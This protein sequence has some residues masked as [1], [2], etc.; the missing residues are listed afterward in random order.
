M[1]TFAGFA[2][3]ADPTAPGIITD[4]ENLVHT[5]RGYAGVNSL[6][7]PDSIP[8]LA[9]A[10]QGAAVVTKLDG[11]RRILAGTAAAIY[12]LSSGSWTDRSKALGYSGGAESQWSI[13]QFGDSTLMANGSNLIQRSTTGAFADVT[14]S[15][16][17]DIIFTVGAFVMALNV[18]S[19]ADGWHCCAAYDE[20]DWT[21][22]VTTQS[23]SGRLVSAPGE[24]ISGGSLGEYAIAYKQRSIFLGQYVGGSTIWDWTQVR[25]GNAGCVGKRAWCNVNGI[26]F[27]VGEDNFW[28]FDGVTPVPLA[29][30]VLRDWFASEWSATYKYKTVCAFDKT[31]NLVWIFYAS[32]NATSLDSAL[33]YHV[34]AKK[35][36]RAIVNTETALEYV[37]AG[38][39]IDGLSGISATIDGL[40]DIPFDSP[41]W[42]AGGRAL[43]V[44]NP[45]HQLQSFT[46]PSAWS[47]F[48]TGEYGDDYYYS[49]LSGVKLRFTQSP[50]AGVLQIYEKDN[51]GDTFVERESVDL[52][53][54][55][56]DV[57]RS[58]RWHK[59]KI[60]FTGNVEVT[61][62]DAKY[63]QDGEQ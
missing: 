6:A 15:P 57:L 63:M 23:A 16:V 51:S 2:P 38:I 11:S 22:S 62:M 20:T 31:T 24:I 44:F 30:G 41:Y 49:L 7:T 28:L 32:T 43:A 5:L 45:S 54:G 13:A 37:S 33:V 46:A 29:D 25:G 50:T 55:K 40:V 19:N 17:A 59:A 14:G 39:T 42:L 47:S 18:D 48:T 36:G 8:A 56:F 61:G 21:E 3:D 34:Q 10:C 27:V 1:I 9:A 58:A 4:C 53:N 12:E 35:W 60:S 52:T 26:H